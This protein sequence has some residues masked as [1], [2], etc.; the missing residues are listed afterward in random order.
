M[1]L[2]YRRR[3]DG[4]RSIIITE[5]YHHIVIRCM[6]T[7]I[8]LLHI[9]TY[10]SIKCLLFCAK[11]TRPEMRLIAGFQFVWYTIINV[12]D[13]NR[14]NNSNYYYHY[15]HRLRVVEL[16]FWQSDERCCCGIPRRTTNER[17]ISGAR[18][19]PD[20]VSKHNIM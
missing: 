4:G 14:N 20:D 8:T 13:F 15:Y 11:Y 1:I 12:R 6:Y 7:Y 2:Y 18:T 16:L 9:Y 19:L 10:S 3:R 17:H 5:L